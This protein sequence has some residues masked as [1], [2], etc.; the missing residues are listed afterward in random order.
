MLGNAKGKKTR[1]CTIPYG[2]G[3][4]EFHLPEEWDIEVIAPRQ[5]DA[6]KNPEQEISREIGR[7]L[8]TLPPGILNGSSAARH[9]AAI[10]VNDQTRPVPHRQL[11]PPLIARLEKA[12]CPRSQITFFIATGSHKPPSQEQISR[13]LPP[14]ITRGC[15]VQVHNCRASRQLLYLGTTR[16]GTPCYVNRNYARASLKIV[17]GNIE[18]HQ[19]MGWSG[20]AKSA[21]IGLAGEQTITANHK[22]L[23]L[24]NC[25]PGRYGDN[26]LRMDVEEMGRMIKVHMALNVVLNSHKDIAGVFAGA[27]QDVME[28]AVCFAASR[29]TVPSGPPADLVI[30]SPGGYPKDIDLY[31]S[32]KAL[33]HGAMAA[34]PHA[35][36]ILAAECSAGVG[37][38]LYQS[39]MQNKTSFTEVKKAYAKEE[40]RLG[41]HKAKLIAD[42]A[43]GRRVYL[44][45]SLPEDTVR[46][47]LFTPGTSVNNCIAEWSSRWP[48]SHQNPRVLIFPY[49]NATVPEPDLSG[50]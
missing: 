9:R 31:Q 12:G 15:G 7:A 45:S 43:D 46:S 11:L 18:P 29:F 36:I 16:L 48:E 44:H 22:N 10:A 24:P 6:L 35:D 2:K 47:L 38:N 17:V 33:R 4:Q 20:G 32:Q 39:W 28:R 50:L 19:F 41:V 13:I 30:A 3:F 5:G 26:P 37:H 42:D 49:A 25:A 21:A 14:D 34:K 27:P 23:C 1:P 40:F 8:K